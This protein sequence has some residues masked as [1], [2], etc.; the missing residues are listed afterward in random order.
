MRRILFPLL[1]IGLAGGLFT[2]GSGAF[3][4]DV[5]TDTGNTITAGTA[6]LVIGSTV[7]SC[8]YA[9]VAPG[10][11]LSACA[12][13]LNMAGSLNDL[14]LD[15]EVHVT[16]VADTCTTENCNGAANLSAADIAVT[17]CS[18]A[19]GSCPFGAVA[20]LA[21]IVAAGCVALDADSAA[22]EDGRVLSLTFQV[23]SSIANNT[24]GDGLSIDFHFGLSQQ[25]DA[26]PS[27]C[28]PVGAT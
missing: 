10:Q 19:G 3:F 24:Q 7:S 11:A 16:Q 2:L 1:V 14:H 15:V 13:T 4:S 20:T 23:S 22:N 27:R 5:E 26:S 17:A 25:T 8:D 12:I 21:D 28:H 6:D 9:G 18:F